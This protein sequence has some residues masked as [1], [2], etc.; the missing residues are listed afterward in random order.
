M[1]QLRF[2][3]SSQ[4]YYRFHDGQ[5]VPVPEVGYLGPTMQASR[6]VLQG[7]VRVLGVPVLP[8][9]WLA[10][11]FDSAHL[12]ANRIYAGRDAPDE[13]YRDQ[14][15]ALRFADA[16]EAAGLEGLDCAVA[17]LCRFLEG[18]LKP[19]S[20]AMVRLVSLIDQW[21]IGEDSPRIEDLVAMTGL[22]ARQIARYTNRAYGAAPKLLAR[23][24]RA[25]RCARQIVVE[26]KN[27]TDLCDDDKFYD[28]PH[29]I[30]EIKQFL[31][32]TPYQLLHDPATVAR[33]AVESRN[34][35]GHLSAR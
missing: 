2:L 7:E 23:K 14:L 13:G 35:I 32:Y 25:L 19:V 11:G 21:L 3:L 29:F 24:Y 30:R 16:R 17:G 4:G 18:R 5:M 34:M 22:S 26:K 27:W 8:L 15:K 10:L 6:F 33:L 20:P 12:W 28:Q 1:P 9:G 31:G